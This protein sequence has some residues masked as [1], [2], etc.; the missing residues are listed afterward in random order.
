MHTQYPL[1]KLPL[2]VC[3]MAAQRAVS[4]SPTLSRFS[5]HITLTASIRSF[6]PIKAF[7]DGNFGTVW[8]CDWHGPLPPNTPMST[9]QT[10]VGSR[11]EYT[12]TRL[13]AVKRMKN[14]WEGGW[15]ECRRLK[16]LEVRAHPLS[17]SVRP[18]LITLGSVRKSGITCNTPS[19]KHH[20]PVRLFSSSR[21]QGTLLRVRANGRAFVSAHQIPPWSRSSTLCRWSRR[22]HFPTDCP[23]LTSHP[24]FWLL[25]SGHE[26]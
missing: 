6:T 12:N 25:S 23:G 11:P 7:G 2:Q 1:S 3:N 14:R 10:V 26:T 4:L 15:D 16:E 21:D 22:L 5:L 8:L 9:M 18:S 17:S 24:C 13:V 19:S 20:T